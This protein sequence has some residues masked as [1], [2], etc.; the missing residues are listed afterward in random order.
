MSESIREVN[1]NDFEQVVLGSDK[2]V[3]VDFW[4]AWCAPCRALAPT[5]E[6][7]AVKRAERARVVKLDVDR[8]PLATLRYRVHALPTLI[9]FSDGKE[10]E[11]LLGAVSE[12][13]LS[14][15]SISTSKQILIRR[16]RK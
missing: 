11:R 8:N 16:R 14:A 12:A 1:D 10:V 6:A 4:A 5:I 7:I 15:G 2:P 9:L 3:L 13:R